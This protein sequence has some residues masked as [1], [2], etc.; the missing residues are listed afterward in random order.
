M[1]LLSIMSIL[2]C[3]IVLSGDG[4]QPQGVGTENSPYLVESLD[5]LLWITTNQ[6]SWNSHFLQTSNIDASETESWNDGHGFEPIGNMYYA[7]GWVYESFSGVYGGGGYSISNLYINN[8]TSQESCFGLFRKIENATVENLILDNFSI[9]GKGLIGLL[10]GQMENSEVN[11]VVANGEITV[12]DGNVGGLSAWIDNSLISSCTTEINIT[13]S[14]QN[15]WHNVMIGGF[16]GELSDH[17]QV[18]DCQSTLNFHS[19]YKV[20]YLGGFVGRISGT[21]VVNNCSSS[22]IMSCDGSIIGGFVGSC[23]GKIFNS[24]CYVELEYVNEPCYQ[25]GGFVGY[26]EGTDITWPSYMWDF[27]EINSCSAAGSIEGWADLGGF[28]GFGSNF[29]LKN[30]YTKTDITAYEFDTGM[31]IFDPHYIGTFGGNITIESFPDPTI[32]LGAFSSYSANTISLVPESLADDFV[33]GMRGGGYFMG[34]E[35][36]LDYELLGVNQEDV[37]GSLAYST[38][39]MKDVETYTSNNQFFTWDFVGNPFEDDQDNDYWDIDPAINDGYPYLTNSFEVIVSNEDSEQV[40][41]QSDIMI[42]SLYPNPFNPTTTISY[43]LSKKSNVLVDVFNIKGQKVYSEKTGVKEVGNHKFI[44]NGVNSNKNSVASG[45]YLFKIKT[46]SQE[47]LTKGIL[48][49]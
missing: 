13:I 44:W 47:C 42:N 3:C 9:Y 14:N 24:S 29:N 23:D 27:P 49:K 35:C 37:H 11:N 6:D 30:C 25:V 40:V 7:P 41:I 8:P 33:Y 15:F 4:I 5:N 28:V 17:S 10:C 46:E 21:S 36:Y 22:A 19:E 45:V 48:M 39:E 31:H 12:A 2:L 43:T 18:T 38:E 34:Y 1:K 26:I 16:V 20:T 32:I